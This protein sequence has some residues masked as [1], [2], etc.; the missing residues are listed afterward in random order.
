[1][2]TS[3]KD[4]EPG[5]LI[6]RKFQ[7]KKIPEI[8]SPIME[9][10]LLVVVLTFINPKIAD[11]IKNMKKKNETIPAIIVSSEPLS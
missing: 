5:L 1:M 10:T 7:S 11:R 9:N 3:S 4:K 6:I 8:E 2:P